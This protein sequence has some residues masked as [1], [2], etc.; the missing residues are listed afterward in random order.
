MGGGREVEQ[1]PEVGGERGVRAHKRRGA[2]VGSAGG[3]VE[4]EEG[5]G[6]AAGGAVVGP[7]G[8]AMAHTE[9]EIPTGA[10]GNCLADWWTC[11]FF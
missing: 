4:V 2:G 5:V 8:A 11:L 3:K 10:D 6:G 1:A 9:R 7:T